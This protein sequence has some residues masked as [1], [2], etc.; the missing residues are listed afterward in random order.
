V[1]VVTGFLRAVDALASL[2]A[3]TSSGYGQAIVV[4]VVLLGLIGGLAWRNR[5]RSVPAAG[6]GL[7]PLRRTSRLELGAAAGAIIVAG[8]LGTL[9][10][11]VSGNARPEPAISISGSDVAT[12]GSA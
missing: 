3:L 10:P 9:A 5:R 12:S 7:G 1:V 11:P 8:L 6:A 2:G 4:K